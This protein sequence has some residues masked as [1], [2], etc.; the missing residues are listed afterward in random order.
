M[1][2]SG[3]AST[4]HVRDNQV[5]AITESFHFAFS[6]SGAP[7]LGYRSSKSATCRLTVTINQ[8]FTPI[9]LAKALAYRLCTYRSITDSGDG[10][11]CLHRGCPLVSAP[12]SRAQ[13]ELQP[14]RSNTATR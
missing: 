9:P 14:N 1:G 11:R 5:S 7:C 6:S 3:I 10:V 4:L 8:E 12:Y 2:Q 13:R